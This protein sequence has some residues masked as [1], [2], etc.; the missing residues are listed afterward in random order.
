MNLENQRMEREK[1]ALYWL[2]RIPFLGSVTVGRMRSCTESYE[3]IYNIEGKT[4]EAR[5][6]LSP[7]KARRMETERGKIK[8]ALE[9]YHS[10]AQ[11]GIRFITILDQDYPERFQGLEGRPLWLSVKGRLPDSHRPALAIIGS[12][13]ATRYGME[14]AECFG[15]ELAK[16]GI[17][18]V[19]GLAAGIDGAGQKGA[20]E[21]G[22]DTYGVLGCGINICYPREH[23]QLYEEIVRSGG[24]ISEYRLGEPPVA[25]NFPVRNRIIS[26]LSDDILV[27]E[28]REKSGSLITVEQGL[29]QGKDIFAVPGRITDPGSAGC[30]QLIQ[31]GAYPVN[32]P[33]DI[34]EYFGI[35]F[36]KKLSLHEKNEKGL[37]KKEKMVYSFIDLHPKHLEDIVSECGLP[38]SECM[39]ILLDLEL[40]GFVTSFGGNYYGRKL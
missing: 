17:Q 16:E 1:E 6:I 3:E 24:M 20:L 31:N 21:G 19:S 12:R 18:I 15:R 36:Q 28:A 10:L 9:E 27:V 23:Y 29:N 35:R 13:S 30:N 8:E 38:L 32:S 7:D 4:W 25:R 40:K 33:G 34:L 37:A 2:S 5:G 26:G 22:G 11:R 14:I 39:M